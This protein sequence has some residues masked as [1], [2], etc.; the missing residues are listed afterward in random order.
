MGLPIALGTKVVSTYTPSLP[1][2]IEEY[3][4]DGT[5]LHP[6]PVHDS[7]SLVCLATNQEFQAVVSI[8]YHD[9]TR[10]SSSHQK[11]YVVAEL[12][13]QISP[14]SESFSLAYRETVFRLPL[15]GEGALI[16]QHTLGRCRPQAV[17]SVDRRFLT[18]L[19]PF[20]FTTETTIV[21]FQLRRPRSNS[22][23]VSAPPLPSYIATNPAYE[24]SEVPV[25]TNPRVLNEQGGSPL[26]AASC[27]CD[28]SLT[29]KVAAI[30]NSSSLLF[31]GC[32]DGSIL[33][34]SYRPLAVMG[35]AHR[36]LGITNKIEGMDH[37]AECHDDTLVRSG[38]LAV[39]DG[40]GD[41][42][43]FRTQ[44]LKDTV[45]FGSGLEVSE[46]AMDDVSIRSV[47]LVVSISETHKIQGPFACAIWVAASYLA[48]MT[49]P[50]EACH[51]SVFGLYDSGK[52]APIS[53]NNFTRARLVE[54]RHT[55]FPAIVCDTKSANTSSSRDCAS[56]SM[57]YDVSSDCL[58]ISSCLYKK[59]FVR[60]CIFVSLW[61]WRSNTQGL[62][63]ATTCADVDVSLASFVSYFTFARDKKNALKLSQFVV[64]GSS[65]PILIRKDLFD[66]G[67]ISPPQGHSS[68][69]S[70]LERQLPLVLTSDTVSFPK[71]TRRSAR[72]EYEIDWAE[73]RIPFNYCSATMA[74][75]GRRWG[76]SVAVAGEYGMC[77]LDIVD[78]TET[79]NSLPRQTRI[80]PTWHRFASD[81]EET[82][83]QVTAMSW[84]EGS[85]KQEAGD[86]MLHDDLV[87]ATVCVGS[88]KGKVHYLACWSKKRLAVGDQL[89]RDWSK[90]SSS[91]GIRLKKDFC[92]TR[93][94]LLLQPLSYS[95]SKASRK[96]VVLL[97][98]DSR[99]T[100]YQIYQLQVA[101]R[102]NSGA[103]PSVRSLCEV[104]TR[105]AAQGSIGGGAHLFVAG[106][107]FAYDLNSV[108]STGKFDAFVAT[109]GA[110]RQ[111]EGGMDALALSTTDVT[112]IVPIVEDSLSCDRDSKDSEV[113]AYW[114]SEGDTVRRGNDAFVWTI[115]L[116]SGKLLAWVVPC[117][118]DEADHAT[119]SISMTV[120][121]S[122]SH[123]SVSAHPKRMS[124]GIVCP[125]GNAAQWML[126]S[127]STTGTEF[128][129]GPLRPSSFG[130]MVGISQDCHKLH[131]SVGEDFET[132]I[133]RS[134]FLMHEFFCPGIFGLY[135][136]NFLPLLYSSLFDFVL[137][138]ASATN[139]EEIVDQIVRSKLAN[140]T[141][142]ESSMVALQLLSLRLVERVAVLNRRNGDTGLQLVKGMFRT[143]VHTTR[144]HTRPLQFAG[145]F[146]EVGRQLEPSCFTHLFPLPTLHGHKRHWESLEEMFDGMLAQGS[147]SLAIAALP[148]FSTYDSTLYMCSSL[149]H[150]CLARLDHALQ[151]DRENLVNLKD[152][153][154]CLGDI[155]RYGIKLED[156]GSV[157]WETVSVDMYSDE[158]DDDDQNRRQQYSIFCGLSRWLGMRLFTKKEE[159]T[160]VDAAAAAFIVDG[161]YESGL[162][163]RSNDHK[164]S[165]TAVSYHELSNDETFA[166][167]VSGYILRNAFSRKQKTYCWADTAMIAAILI[168]D[169]SSGFRLA[170]RAAIVELLGGTPTS[171][172]DE[173]VSS[174]ELGA[175]GYAKILSQ[176]ISQCEE[177]VDQTQ[178]GHFLDLVLILLG[179]LAL[180]NGSRV[181]T[182]GLLFLAIVTGHVANRITY[183]LSADSAIPLVSAYLDAQ[184][185]LNTISSNRLGSML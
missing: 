19:I 182:A 50:N 82:S 93:L 26:L 83:F 62:T 49:Q 44:V 31:V 122:H 128:P 158:D 181:Q 41:A 104:L 67:I 60:E 9:M 33:A 170:S 100:V 130:S 116:L 162:S 160:I 178:A 32:L 148:L 66:A 105:R 157:G 46:R 54:T 152:E 94:D 14:L 85:E 136:P 149:F 87:V 131:R 1:E 47:G 125:A 114:L 40:H 2:P 98:D 28:A 53:E 5:V 29:P 127:A 64:N 119:L 142:F 103:Q 166:D 117:I 123:G 80:H 185:E 76:R 99:S 63:I 65:M 138:D 133:F 81:A 35:C 8:S 84:W 73:V 141:C 153:R 36:S 101:S 169:S 38:R 4:D 22:S 132:H 134:D 144:Q 121:G 184:F 75:L 57:E 155:F 43:V 110:I 174:H 109:L 24:L 51:V 74:T 6:S 3:A 154:E 17:F 135:S 176:S 90:P 102:R 92:P 111:S 140:G 78:E 25:A 59:S 118:S 23:L 39:I 42:K 70:G 150:L 173:F 159:S 61:H 139:H 12:R 21:I 58:A 147:V 96:A 30:A 161:F 89:I 68:N 37:I 156:T 126:L 95:A 11:E 113:S 86:R 88:G 107:S 10:M 18:C 146:L 71:L 168:G 143:L 7:A 91:W 45:D 164:H 183:V 137:D 179:R 34:V 165:Y 124:L 27:L 20:P 13:I 172:L 72:C 77:T 115:H 108:D 56:T 175:G 48:V 106:C 112:H 69:D 177:Q 129:I 151:F 55:Y 171:V 15:L 79:A 16:M 145:L 97:A 120:P 180:S 163:G 52:S 167:I